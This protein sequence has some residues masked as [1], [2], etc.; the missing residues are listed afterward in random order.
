MCRKES[1]TPPA[2][3]PPNGFVAFII[4]FYPICS[5]LYY[6]LYLV[7]FQI[8]YMY[9]YVLYSIFIHK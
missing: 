5:Y 9:L 6:M 2:V 3:L 4:L 8:K 1:E 7:L